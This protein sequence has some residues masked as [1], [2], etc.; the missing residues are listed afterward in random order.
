MTENKI[1]KKP[2]KKAAPNEQ[3][4]AKKIGKKK[5]LSKALR[6]NLLRRKTSKSS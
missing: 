6:E 5:Q 2:Q 3:K 1:T 4:E